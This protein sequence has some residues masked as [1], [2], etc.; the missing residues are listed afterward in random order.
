[1]KKKI[2]IITLIWIIT[3]LVSSFVYGLTFISDFNQ[4]IFQNTVYNGSALKLTLGSLTGFYIS[5]IFDASNTANWKD[6]AW[7]SI[8]LGEIANNQQGNL[9]KG[10]VLLMH[11]NE[12][13]G[14]I[15]DSSGNGNNGTQSGGITYS[16]PGKLNNAISFDGVNDYIKITTAPFAAY[17]STISLWFYTNKIATEGAQP[18]HKMTLISDDNIYWG[19]QISSSTSKLQY[20]YYTTGPQSWQ[21]SSTINT[22]QWYNLIV[23]SNS[24]GSTMYLN[25]LNQGSSSLTWFNNAGGTGQ[26]FYISGYGDGLYSFNGSI[27]EVAMWNRSLSASEILNIYKRGAL[28]LNLS[29]QSCDDALCSGEN[30]TNLGSNLTSPQNL[31]VANNSYF[32]YKFDFETINFTYSPEV[33]NLTIEYLLTNQTNQTENSSEQNHPIIEGGS[34]GET[35]NADE[36]KQIVIYSYSKEELTRQILSI[37]IGVLIFLGLVILLVYLLIRVMR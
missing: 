33:Y 1:M 27:D 29:V 15:V 32:Q 3:I 28:K 12:A 5:P 16:A 9:S 19:L 6:I 26:P 4:G 11:L 8:E 7:S 20:Y 37:I 21:S 31:N 10:N 13:S 23:I 22:G 24:T 25:G 36:Q 14:T 2:F 30:F 35:N 17:P 18:W 34:T